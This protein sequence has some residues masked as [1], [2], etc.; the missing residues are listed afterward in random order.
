MYS[1]RVDAGVRGLLK[2]R[3]FLDFLGPGEPGGE[4]VVVEER[5]VDAPEF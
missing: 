2:S 4:R 3:S 5:G 1:T